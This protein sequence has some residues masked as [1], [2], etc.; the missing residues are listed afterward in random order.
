MENIDSDFLILTDGQ[1]D[2]LTKNNTF[3]VNLFNKVSGMDSRVIPPLSVTGLMTVLANGA[4]GE[5][6]QEILNTIGFNDASMD[7]INAL[8]GYL[9]KK[10][11]NLDPSTTVNIADYIAVN[12]NFKIKDEF[13]NTVSDWFKAEAANLDFT[14]PKTADIINNWCSR[15]TDKMIPRIIDSV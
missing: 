7:E 10:A 11:G 14:S 3:A 1:M 2:L 8:Y 9:V 15:H 12:K 4:D 13:K 5:T 6:R